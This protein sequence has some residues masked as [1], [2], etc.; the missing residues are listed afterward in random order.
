MKILLIAM[1][2]LF[3][4]TGA[5]E[6]IGMPI[7]PSLWDSYLPAA[8][9]PSFASDLGAQRDGKLAF[10]FQN[11]DLAHLSL[12]V[13]GLQIISANT[14]WNIN[15]NQSRWF[16]DTS[17]NWLADTARYRDIFIVAGG[18]RLSNIISLNN[19]DVG[20]GFTFK[21]LSVTDTDEKKIWSDSWFG[22]SLSFSLNSLLLSASLDKYEH[23]YRIAIIEPDNWQ[24][25][26][27]FYQNINDFSSFGVQPGAE[28]IFYE[29]IKFH[30]GMRWQFAEQ[31]SNKR[32]S[33]V[34]FLL[35]F[36]TSIR[37]RP[38]RSGDP[39]WIQPIIAPFRGLS[40]LY[41]WEIAFDSMVDAKYG[42]YNWL[43]SITKW[44]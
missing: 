36:G 7:S 15:G 13:P 28:W 40:A 32:I 39:N 11:A 30:S 38:Y 41:N 23:R 25:G 34:E 9:H 35:N 29:S 44:F 27:E 16:Y 4:S 37:F 42:N 19:W 8:A 18:G 10:G 22:G 20:I 33:R 17:K 21:N 43:I 24:A 1:L 14:K 6:R 26:L 5:V 31:P 2:L 12:S 3:F